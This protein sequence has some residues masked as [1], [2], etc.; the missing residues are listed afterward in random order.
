[1]W[2]VRPSHLGVGLPKCS[3]SKMVYTTFD[4]NVHPH[5][6]ICAPKCLRWELKGSPQNAWHGGRAG[7]WGS[8]RT[9]SGVLLV[10]PTPNGV[11]VTFF[12]KQAPK[13][14]HQARFMT[15]M[16][17]HCFLEGQGW[18]APKATE[19]PPNWNLRGKYLKLGVKLWYNVHTQHCSKCVGEQFW[20][21]T[22]YHN[23]TPS[24]RYLT[25]KFQFLGHSEALGKPSLD[26]RGK[27]ENRFL[28]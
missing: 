26:L 12:K 20:V 9:I 27:S 28:P 1:M 5:W 10:P 11:L 18:A 13:I 17:F 25:L 4:P 8:W 15:N 16:S 22:L 19:C 3:T 24:L 7:G 14:I 21:W 6:D 23:F 2:L